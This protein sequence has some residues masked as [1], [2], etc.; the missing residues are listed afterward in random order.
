[1]DGRGPI[2]R[3]R[4]PADPPGAGGNGPGRPPAA[5]KKLKLDI[6]KDYPAAKVKPVLDACK[7]AGFG[8]VELV[9]APLNPTAPA[10]AAAPAKVKPAAGVAHD[11]EPP[12]VLRVEATFRDGDESA[13]LTALTV[14]GE[15]VVRPDAAADAVRKHL[16]ATATTAATGR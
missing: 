6:D 10:N 9:S 16:A 7:A 11:I 13:P 5:P 12:D 8:T 1:M 14:A 3:R 15:Y 2:L 4:E